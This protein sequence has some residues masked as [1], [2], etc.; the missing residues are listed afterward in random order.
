MSGRVMTSGTPSYTRAVDEDLDIGKLW[1]VS[2]HECSSEV[3]RVVA[4]PRY[5]HLRMLPTDGRDIY[6]VKW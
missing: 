4:E 2:S 1:V 6:L 3:G 5:T